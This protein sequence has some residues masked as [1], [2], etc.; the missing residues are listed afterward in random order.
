MADDGGAVADGDSGE[1]AWAERMKTALVGTSALRIVC[2]LA[3]RHLFTLMVPATVMLTPIGLLAAAMLPIVA[4]DHLLVVNGRI[5]L[6]GD[7][8]M[9]LFAWLG[10]LLLVSVP[11]AAVAGAATMV[12]AAGRALG[13]PVHWRSALQ[14]AVRRVRGLTALAFIQLALL[15]LTLAVG[16]ALIVFLNPWVGIA[17]TVVI[18]LVLMPTLLAMPA[19]VL[20]GLG[21]FGALSRGYRLV[22][23]MRFTSP[24]LLAISMI[25][26]PGLAS[27]GLGWVADRLPYPVDISM[28]SVTAVLLAALQAAV[29]AVIFLNR[30]AE[31]WHG[32][33]RPELRA[34]VDRLP[35]QDGP[36]TRMAAVLAVLVLPGLLTGAF[37]A[38][39]P[40]GW[41]EVSDHVA[42]LSPV[43]EAGD[44]SHDHGPSVRS[45]DLTA[46]YVSPGPK[47]AMYMQAFD[48][49]PKM[50]T[51]PDLTCADLDI[52]YAG[53]D[54][55]DRIAAA[56][57]LPDGRTVVASWDWDRAERNHR[58]R[59]VACDQA[60][61]S[62]PGKPI[63]WWSRDDGQ[64][65]STKLAVAA[66][67]GGVVLVQADER[68]DD[69]TLTFT[70]CRDLGCADPVRHTPVRLKRDIKGDSDKHSLKLAFGPDG[71]PVAA[72][73]DGDT[74][75]VSLVTCETADC[76]SATV[77]RPGPPVPADE[78][79]EAGMRGLSLAVR[80][81]GRPVIAYGDPRAGAIKLLDCQD[82][83]CSGAQSTTL[84]GSDHY[85][86][87]PGLGLSAD[88]ALVATFVGKHLVVYSCQG[89]ACRAAR[90]AKARYSPGR[91]A[92]SLDQTGR[93]VIAWIDARPSLR[94]PE[95]SLRV[96]S[97]LI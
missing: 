67:P 41:V 45:Q 85:N 8:S 27:R 51:C 11:A 52:F 61:C 66:R 3:L 22:A 1:D 78:V 83:A 82:R 96:T 33:S 89:T 14:A 40:L 74:G 73:R 71:R 9:P 23:T 17:A 58:L 77:T 16:A 90:I 47:L 6:V 49:P 36:R 35:E 26:L 13:R 70:S 69:K 24:I 37:A 75:A 48:D 86:V 43:D 30:I 79:A 2:T 18:G 65:L 54:I 42:G 81:D 7:A 57:A 59:L 60:R 34:I 94:E 32:V 38:V 92:M 28:N 95:W 4:A 39:N 25:I 46:L 97:P 15:A 63:A 31:Q 68:D 21:P 56:A 12:I 76:A 62:A 53:D 93:P 84:A 20:E 29:L 91:L 87:P 80:R 50:L 55:F 44:D 10:G 88:Q 64:I 72:V 19:F 5:E